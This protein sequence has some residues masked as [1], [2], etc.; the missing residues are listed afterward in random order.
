VKGECI[1]HLGEDEAV[2]AAVSQ[3]GVAPP[4]EQLAGEV[5]SAGDPSSED[6]PARTCLSLLSDE[7]LVG[8]A[9]GE[10]VDGAPAGEPVRSRDRDAAFNALTERHYKAVRKVVRAMMGFSPDADD[11]V[12]SAFLS[13][14]RSLASLKDR[15]RFKY[16]VRIIAVNEARDVLR[17]QVDTDGLDVLL[18]LPE[19]AQDRIPPQ[20]AEASWLIEE[21]NNRLPQQYMR[22]LYLRYYLDYTVNE[23]ADVLG[24]QPGLVKWRANRARR[25]ARK[26]LSDR[27]AISKDNGKDYTNNKGGPGNE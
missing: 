24:I 1:L 4:G 16:W 3:D 15:S 25:L 5:P 18:T 27:D 10:R 26:A 8:I 9:L 2:R 17:G 19:A 7:T 12:Q 14:Y 13:V 6:K 20:A 23:V 22:V 11:V 21:L